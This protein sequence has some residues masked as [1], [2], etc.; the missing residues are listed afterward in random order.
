M[1]WGASRAFRTGRAAAGVAKQG[2]QPKLFCVS[3]ACRCPLD[4]LQ[5]MEQMHMAGALPAGASMGMDA[6][7]A[8]SVAAV[9]AAAAAEAAAAAAAAAAEGLPAEGQQPGGEVQPPAAA[10]AQ[11]A[12]AAAAAAAAAEQ[13]AQQ[14]QA[15][16]VA[17]G[18]PPSYRESFESEG[19]EG[20]EGEEEEDEEYSTKVG[21]AGV[22]ME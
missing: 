9:Q 21:G 10:A 6:A 12:A 22:I 8:D 15:A 16:A 17:A 1:T 2:Q 11:D 19:D 7:H 20:A 18:I 3:A 5:V 4:A 14:L 13:Q